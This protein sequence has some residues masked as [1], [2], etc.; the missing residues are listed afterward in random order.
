MDPACCPLP[1]TDAVPWLRL[2][3]GLFIASQTMLFALAVSLT[4]PE[5][6]RALFL[7]HLAMLGAT[8]VVMALRGWPLLLES[9]RE[10]RR[11]R[12]T[13]E[14]LFLA[15]IAG[16]LGASMQSMVQGAGPVYF[17]VVSILLIVYSIGHA[18]NRHSRGKALA[19]MQSIKSDTEG[20]FAAF[21]DEQRQTSAAVDV[22]DRKHEP[23]SDLHAG[24]LVRPR[25]S[26]SAI[27]ADAGSDV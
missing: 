14:L 18:I 21:V 2:V 27:P 10:L 19:A 9:L 11:R 4:P 12:V 8:A 22:G 3:I 15:G 25:Q 13:M 5:D 16:A 1:A 17:D 23:S 20:G 24:N 7:L 6:P 26:I